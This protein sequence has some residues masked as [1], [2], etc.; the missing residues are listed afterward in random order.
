MNHLIQPVDIDGTLYCVKHGATTPKWR[1]VSTVAGDL[2]LGAGGEDGDEW[3]LPNN[4]GGAMD[5]AT[6]CIWKATVRF[7]ATGV[8]AGIGVAYE[9]KING[10]DV[11][12]GSPGVIGTYD[13]VVD[14]DALGLMGRACGNIWDIL[15]IFQ[16]S[17]K[18]LDVTFGPPV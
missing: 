18:I 9:V 5:F 16:G 2:G 10:V 14:L 12:S 1:T 4:E 17:V 11:G 13:V 15:A 7:I 6:C 8:V 3:E